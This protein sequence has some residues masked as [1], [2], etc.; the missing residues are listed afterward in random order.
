MSEREPKPKVEKWEAWVHAALFTAGT[1]GLMMERPWSFP[2][3]GA[4]L[5]WLLIVAYRRR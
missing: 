3:M 4:W 5:T 2:V 1:Y